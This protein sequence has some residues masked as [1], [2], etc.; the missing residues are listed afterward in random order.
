MTKILNDY[1][2]AQDLFAEDF[3][4][5]TERLN[6]VLDEYNEKRATQDQETE[7]EEVN[8]QVRL[9]TW[10]NSRNDF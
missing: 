7:E 6:A 10:S 8:N 3:P 5:D 4:T 9:R 2:K 1:L